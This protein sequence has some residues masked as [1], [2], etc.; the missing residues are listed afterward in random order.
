M[1]RFSAKQFGILGRLALF[2]TTL[3][4]GTSFVILKSTLD[5][6]E[7]LYV[8]A[9]R[10]TGAAILLLLIS[11]G[12]LRKLDR[13]YI[14]GGVLMGV[15]LFL[16][17][18]L[19]TY[20]LV[21][22]TPGVNAFLTATYCVIVPFVYWLFW[23][24]KTDKYNI[25]AVLTCIIGMALIFLR[26]GL[27]IGIGELLT[28]FCGI[29][30]ALHIVVTARSAENRSPALLSMLQFATAAV[31]SWI[32][33]LFTSPFP[34]DVPADA[35]ISIA[36]LCVMCTAVCF[37][38]QT[39]GQKYTPPSAAA[40]I[41]T[42]ESTFGVIFSIIFGQEIL[43][44]RLILGFVFIFSAVLISETKLLFFRHRRKSDSAAY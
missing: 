17:Y 22:T 27:N 16:A 38:L 41:L 9:F 12:E 29:F 25:I 4:W 42:L 36:Y 35:V 24:Q 8:L 34:K 44:F 13:G 2:A 1:T 43:S 20:G 40:V 10:F 31:L 26:D 19:Q 39:I 6:V 23:R 32:S 33:A 11:L 18:V 3:I 21:Y 37:L 14:I 7:T 28:A 5:S 15:C 30:Y